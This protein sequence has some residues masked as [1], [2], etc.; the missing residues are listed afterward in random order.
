M[1]QLLLIGLLVVIGCVSVAGQTSSADDPNS[2][3]LGNATVVVPPPGGFVDVLDLI[4]NDHGRFASNDLQGLLA[5]DVPYEILDRL[6]TQPLMPLDI[7]TRVV[8]SPQ[9][10]ERFIKPEIF[11]ATVAEYKKNFASLTDPSGK[12]M[13]ST[14][15]EMALWTS[16]VRGKKT[17][18]NFDTPKNLGFFNETPNLLSTMMLVTMKVDDRPVPMLISTSMLRVN[19]RL[20]N[21]SVYKR[22]PS[23][24]DIEVI[25][26]FTKSWTDAIFAANK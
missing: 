22:S 2:H 26:A 13:T 16:Q 21:V 10:R 6:K 5:I 20:I 24:K 9:I 18:I 11:A 23:E 4:P 1:K 14:K 17:G 19:G 8:I 12:I 15:T 3:K 7:Y 25:T